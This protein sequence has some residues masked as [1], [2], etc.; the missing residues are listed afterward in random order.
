MLHEISLRVEL[1]KGTKYVIIPSPRNKGSLGDFFLS[2][3]M[4]CELHDVD[5]KRIDD[6]T[7]RYSHIMEEYEKNDSRIPKWKVEWVRN[8]LK[9]MIGKDDCGKKK[10]TLKR[11]KTNAKKGA[12]VIMEVQE[13]E[14]EEMDMS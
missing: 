4:D 6:V 9:D 11:K 14:E 5:I 2:L 13:E 3:Y 1:K 8:N 7:D 12:K 10:T